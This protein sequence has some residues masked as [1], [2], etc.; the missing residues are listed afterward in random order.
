MAD[1]ND[2][3]KQSRKGLVRFTGLQQAF[4]AA[5][6]LK[7]FTIDTNMLLQYF[8]LVVPNFTNVVTC[9]LSIENAAGQV[10]YTGTA[11]ARNATHFVTIANLVPLVD[12]CT[13]KLTLSGAP[14]SAGNVDTTLYCVEKL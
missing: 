12:V 11:L 7:S 8:V 6:T 14:G 5:D 2:A 9:T 1:V 13:I 10:I 3:L 4:G